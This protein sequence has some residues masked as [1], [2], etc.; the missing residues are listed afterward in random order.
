M[1]NPKTEFMPKQE[2]LACFLKKAFER[3]KILRIMKTTTLILLVLSLHVSGFAKSQDKITVVLRNTEWSKALTAVEKASNYRFV[4]SNDLAP[5][6]RKIDLV[7]RDADLPEVMDKLLVS[8]T[9]GYK[10]MPE[11]VVVLYSKNT[12]APE[13]RVSGRITD[14][15]GN[16]LGGASIRVKGTNLGTSANANGEYSITPFAPRT[17]K[18]ANEEGSLRTSIDSISAGFKKLILS[19]KIPST[20]YRGFV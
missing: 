4:Y 8:T 13:V 11:N 3:E 17:P 19:L 7:V 16:P 1:L 15:G 10:V 12:V 20:T 2:I 18:M 9:L 14:E 6:N 5:V